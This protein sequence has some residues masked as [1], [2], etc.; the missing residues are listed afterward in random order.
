MNLLS[1]K[2]LSRS[3]RETPLFT[4][5]SFTLDEG[6]KA[7]LIGKNGSGKSTLLSCIAGS[8]APDE[9]DIMLAKGAGVSFLSQ[10]PV[11]NMDHSIREH[12]FKSESAKLTAIRNYEDICAQMAGRQEADISA[13]LKDKLD[14][15]TEEMT[16]RKLWDYEIH[17]KQ[18]LTTL[19]ITDLEQSMGSLSGGMVKKVALAQV[20][21]D[22]TKILLLDEPTNHLDITTIAWLEEYLRLTDRGVLMVTHDRYFLDNVCSSIYEL[23]RGRIKSYTGNYS[24]YLE[25]KAA[26]AEIEQNTERRIESVLRTEREWLLRGPQARGTKAKARLDAVRRMI[27]REKIKEDKEFAFEVSGRRLGGKILELEHVSKS[28]EPGKP[29][30]EDFS[31]S[32]RKGERLGIFGA[33]GSG[34]TTLLNILTAAILPDTGS[35]TAGQNTV[36][37]YYRQNID[38][39]MF[40]PGTDVPTVLEYIEESAELIT[41]NNGKVLTAARMLEQFGFEGKIQ[42]SPVTALSGGERKRLY[43]V[44]LLM[45]NPNFLVLDEPTNDFDIFTMS[46]LESFLESYTG[47]LIV[48]SHDRCFMDKT[49]D[50]LL[51]L[52][53]SGSVSGF[54]GSCSEYLEVRKT[55][56]ADTKPER[57]KAQKKEGPGET[58]AKPAPSN[59]KQK[60]T[61]KEQKEFESLEE[62]I[63]TS[64]KRKKDLETLLSGGETDYSRMGEL[65]AEYGALCSDLDSQYTRWEELAE[66]EDY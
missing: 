66:L 26:E 14:R 5:A 39:E 34:K 53:G 3:G 15:A 44:R 43:L 10:N 61:F 8:L 7:A 23:D 31:Y 55:I 13:G 40:P 25:K 28:W 51:I 64:E 38:T 4:N 11:Y 17:I 20:L 37:G 24:L 16:K 36:F 19:G 27:G 59:R 6:E 12:I 46:V 52:D 62:E 54:A 21:I 35:V 45:A 50:L 33:N 48:V 29:L 41:M 57:E 60:R 58:S 9:G 30:I 18:I 1:V 56:A 32:F 22:D 42:Y 2:N 65:S 63:G 49:A 47:C